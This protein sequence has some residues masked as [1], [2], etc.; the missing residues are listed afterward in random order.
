MAAQCSLVYEAELQNCHFH[1]TY[2]ISSISLEAKC[3]AH[4]SEE[5]FVDTQS[6]RLGPW[7]VFPVSERL[8]LYQCS[9]TAT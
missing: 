7:G 3:R 6:I 5:I 2:V 1:N 9:E 8:P 4:R